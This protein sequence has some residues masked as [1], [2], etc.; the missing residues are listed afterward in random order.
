MN[1]PHPFKK[2]AIILI[3]LFLLAIPSAA[4][5]DVAPPINPPG[6]NLQPGTSSTQVRMLAE[7]VV[8]AVMVDKEL[9]SA[10]INADFTMRNT[11]SSDET[12]A[13][14]FPITTNDGR[15]TYPEIRNLVI[16][17]EDKLMAIRRVNYPDIHDSAVNVPW[18]EFDYTFPAG[19]DKKI[20]VAYN[21]D[22]SGYVPYTAF[23]YIL[24]SGA[25]WKDTI[26]SAD[27]ILSLPY[28]ASIQIGR[29]HV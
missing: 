4:R 9:G 14:R 19:Q 28:A 15:G 18:A 23:Y 22:G 7:T 25:G 10:R 26:G 3:S 12:L 8:I 20:R 13:V 2:F 16:K 21:V 24:E 11:G 1:L 29:A 17:S 27:I 6:S 5:A